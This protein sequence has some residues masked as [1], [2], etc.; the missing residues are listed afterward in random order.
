MAASEQQIER[1]QN[2]TPNQLEDCIAAHRPVVLSGLMD[3]QVASRSWDLRYLRSRIGAQEVEYVRHSSPRLYWDPRAGLPVKT[4]RFE[5][6]ADKI[7]LAD[8]GHFSYL[9]DDVNSFP[10]LKNDFELPAMMSAKPLVRTKFWLSGKGL[11]TPLHYDPVETFHWVIR[12]SKRFSLFSPGLRRY[13]P[14]SWRSKAP[15]ISQVDPDSAN[16][17]FFPRFRDAVPMDCTMNAGDI[18]Y[19]PAFW[20]HQVYSSDALNVSLNFVWFSSLSRSFRYLPQFA[21]CYRHIAWRLS[22]ARAKARNAHA[23]KLGSPAKP[24]P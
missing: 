24:A 12:G 16:A 13:Y 19:L 15:F 18:L 14:F 22:Q 6:F 9:Q 2:P 3:G 17:S 10:A 5:D 7:L 11:I 4:A 1:I 8:D 23:V 21:R 20:W